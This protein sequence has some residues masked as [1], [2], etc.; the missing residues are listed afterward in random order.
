MKKS[1]LI[2][3][4]RK[5]SGHLLSNYRLSTGPP[6]GNISSYSGD[7]GR[8]DHGMLGASFRCRCCDGIR[9]IA[10]TLPRSSQSR[11]SSSG[12]S[13]LLPSAFKRERNQAAIRFLCSSSAMI[14]FSRT[15]YLGGE[16]LE[17]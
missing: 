6:G 9:P 1:E 2:A 13:S 14:L 3:M 15:R 8:A 7:T 11:L 17:S 10:Q 16:M 12:G 5:G 4:E